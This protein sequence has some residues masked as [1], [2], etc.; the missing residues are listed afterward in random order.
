M[1]DI[2]RLGVFSQP[3]SIDIGD[4]FH[5]EHNLPQRFQ[6]KQFLTH[7]TKVGKNPDALIDRDYKRLSEGDQYVDPGTYER[8]AKVQE[9]SKNISER[10]FYPS[11]PS[12]KATGK[13][14]HFGTIGGM[15]KH[16]NDDDPNAPRNTETAPR[17]FYTNPSKKGGYGT[18]GTT[19]GKQL[20]VM[21]EPYLVSRELEKVERREA[22]GRIP[23]AFQSTHKSG[24]GLF[25]ESV[26]RY[27]PGAFKPRE[28][29]RKP[30]IPKPFTPSHPAKFGYN[31]TISKFPEY[32]PDPLDE[33]L[34]K[35]RAERAA[36]RSK[37]GIFKPNSGFKSRPNSVINPLD[38]TG[39]NPVSLVDTLF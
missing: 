11:K 18:P 10:P 33:K 20:D 7:G 6:G 30:P 27:E 3:G 32:K 15:Y 31:S 29:Q 37:K 8:R 19:I 35:E 17:N 26:F 4:P 5:K 14:T 28:V 2:N 39:P 16:E 21:S 22:R 13:G 1:T 25:D 36:E 38:V 9:K 12:A 23:K 34:A 24:S